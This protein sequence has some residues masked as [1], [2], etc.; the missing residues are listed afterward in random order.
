MGRF[1]KCISCKH[2]FTDVFEKPCF[3]C[4]DKDDKPNYEP[5]TEEIKMTINRMSIIATLQGFLGVIT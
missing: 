3:G 1:R 5:L 2:Q 4:L